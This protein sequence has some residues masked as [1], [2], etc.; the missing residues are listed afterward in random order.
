MPELPNRKQELFCRYM[1]SGENTQG[2]AYELAGYTPSTSNASTLANKEDVK[3]RISELRA[4][5]DRKE[6]QFRIALAKADLDPDDP[7]GKRRELEQYK[8]IDVQNM[9]AENARLAQVAGQF[10]AAKESIKLIGDS[11]DAFGT[12]SPKDKALPNDSKSPL[13]GLTFINGAMEDAADT[14]PRNPLAPP[15]K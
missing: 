9:L 8:L 14:G 3:F 1:A 13:V 2:T 5:H 11:I 6:E 10:G 4:E 12:S 15:T 7:K